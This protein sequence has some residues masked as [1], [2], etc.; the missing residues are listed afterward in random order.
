MLLPAPQPAMATS[1][2]SASLLSPAVWLLS[3]AG[4]VQGL[5][6]QDC[7]SVMQSLMQGHQGQ[8]WDKGVGNCCLALKSYSR[9]IAK[10]ESWNHTELW[11]CLGWK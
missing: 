7:I 11:S 4:I 8:G 6:Q 9:F 3:Q 10:G 1:G 2:S 5:S